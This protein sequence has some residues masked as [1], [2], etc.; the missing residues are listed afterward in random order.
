MKNLKKLGKEEERTY[1]DTLLKLE[2]AVEARDY[3]A[4]GELL[5]DLPKAG[6]F[7]GENKRLVKKARRLHL[8]RKYNEEMEKLYKAL[9]TG[10]VSM[11]REVLDE[12]PSFKKM[13]HP[14]KPYV[15]RAEKRLVEEEK[16]K[17]RIREMGE[18]GPKLLEAGSQPSAIFTPGNLKSK[19]I[20]EYEKIIAAANLLIEEEK[21]AKAKEILKDYSI[22]GAPTER[23]EKNIRFLKE[24]LG[25]KYK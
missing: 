17:E 14:Y 21:F 18:A 22:K 9:E 15:R 20:L 1:L 6:K 13:P 25:I 12:I 7:R 19:R 8:Q 2:D 16:S 4:L 24:D 23:L 5:D 11:L 3:E 10:N